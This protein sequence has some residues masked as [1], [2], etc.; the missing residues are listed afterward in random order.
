MFVTA[1][2]IVDRGELHTNQLMWAQW[3]NRPGEEQGTVSESGDVYSKKSP[4]VIVLLTPLVVLGRALPALGVWQAALFFGPVLISLNVVLVHA[5]ARQ[6][7]FGGKLSAL[8]AFA[9]LLA[10]MAWMYSKMSMGES[11][12]SLGLML[13]VIQ[14]HRMSQ[15][16]SETADEKS[17]AGSVSAELICGIGV[18][19]AIG[20]TLVYTL[21]TPIFAA[22]IF[23]ARRR[24]N[25]RDRALG[26]F[27]F[28]LPVGA[29][30][31]A[32]LAYN[33][34]RFGDAL[35]TGYHFVAGQEGFTT[36][37]WYGLLGLTISPARG[38]VW[39]NLSSFL[40]IVGWRRFHRAH[41]AISWLML[42]IVAS[43]F[44]VFGKWWGWW[45]A[46]W[47]PRYLLPLAPLM[48]IASLPLIQSARTRLAR[49]GIALV[50]GASFVVQLSA[51]SIDYNIYDNELMAQFP[52]KPGDTL[53]Y[54]QHPSL[55][56][57][58]PR[59]PILAHLSRF[60]TAPKDFWWATPNSAPTIP[61]IIAR[62]QADQF[63]G[64]AIVYLGPELVEALLATPRLPET[65]GLPVNVPPDDSLAIQF[66]NRALRDPRRV[67]LITWYGAG[68]KGNWYEKRLRHEWASVHEEF[69]DGFRLL[70]FAR[71]PDSNSSRPAGYAFGHIRLTQY[72]LQTDDS[73]LYVSLSWEA[74]T[75]PPENYTSFVHVIAADGSLLAGQDR[76]PL[77]GFRP[78]AAWQPGE[79]IADRFA[80]ALT[81]EQ[82]NG[83][84]IEVGWYSWP[85]LERLPLDG[86]GDSATLEW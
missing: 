29:L 26:L 62:I 31:A 61:G 28:G 12:A 30:G 84:R 27:A 45:S 78:T 60:V 73:M 2:N 25:W 66:F 39:Y 33:F 17:G 36:P 65:F 10:T 20:S 52:P 40:A 86:G 49:G 14:I 83:A 67:W 72:S 70:L 11:M 42:A 80:F 32:L 64:D 24:K 81:A 8:A 9:Y 13:A 56:F 3:A 51:V 59:S 57:D 18:M 21:F 85:S 50:L 6:L 46:A 23:H 43:H 7:G 19:L 35:Q 74:A 41:R 77:G 15:S 47:G 69:T 79:I 55:V 53:L 16:A 48:I 44:L 54:Y 68:D 5:F 58:I 1:V 37:L 63:D 4:L 82:L 71:P 38:F 34:L 76:Q 22:A 75:P